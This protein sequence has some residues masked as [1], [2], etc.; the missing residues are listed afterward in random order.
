[1]P[2]STIKVVCPKCGRTINKITAHY[3]EGSPIGQWPT[4]TDENECRRCKQDR[5]RIL[6][7]VAVWLCLIAFFIFGAFLLV[8]GVM[9]LGRIDNVDPEAVSRFF[10]IAAVLMTFFVFTS[11]PNDGGR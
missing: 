8:N 9:W 2:T 3:Q 7:T 1:M 10:M 11:Y 5:W 6:E 4:L